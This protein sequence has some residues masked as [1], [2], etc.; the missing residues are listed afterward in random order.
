ML[1]FLLQS[2]VVS[3]GDAI[4]LAWSPDGT[5]FA[6][7]TTGVT[8]S[9]FRSSSSSSGGGSGG[10]GGGAIGAIRLLFVPGRPPLAHDLPGFGIP[11]KGLFEGLSDH[12]ATCFW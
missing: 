4:L 7:A 1:D 12:W 2:F 10:G 3:G 8:A 5:G 11:Y 6:A 9:S